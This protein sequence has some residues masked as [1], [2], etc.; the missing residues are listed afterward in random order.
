MPSL[1][2]A[3]R[4]KRGGVVTINDAPIY[5]GGPRR[6][7]VAAR[8]ANEVIDAPPSLADAV[9]RS[10]DRMKMT[11]NDTTTQWGP[12]T[13]THGPSWPWRR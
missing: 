11:T 5:G 8:P 12:C 3:L 4:A 2:D 10:E 7:T 6:P 13:R 1:A 9:Q